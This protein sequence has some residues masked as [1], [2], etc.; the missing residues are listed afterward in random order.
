MHLKDPATGPG[1]QDTWL[2]MSGAGPIGSMR[3]VGSPACLACMEIT[4]LKLLTDKPA[5]A[6]A[7]TEPFDDK[8]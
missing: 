8:V 1:Q 4:P 7:V 2:D 5:P 6:V 3:G